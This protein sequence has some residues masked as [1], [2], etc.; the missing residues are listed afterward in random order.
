MPAPAPDALTQELQ[1]MRLAIYNALLEGDVPT[2]RSIIEQ[3][4][5]GT[6][7]LDS[8]SGIREV[9]RLASR[10]A[11]PPPPPPKKTPGCQ[12]QHASYVKE[13]FGLMNKAEPKVSTRHR[14]R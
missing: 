11:K 1:E 9:G 14:N 3:F 6:D 10:Y 12:R 8:A 2:L 7:H 13:R 4:I 5:L